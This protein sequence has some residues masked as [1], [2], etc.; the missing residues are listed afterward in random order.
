MNITGMVISEELEKITEFFDACISQ[1]DFS[2]DQVGIEDKR[3]QDLLHAIEFEPQAKE[4]YK[5]STKLHDSRVNRR[6]NK[7]QTEVLRPLYDFLNDERHRR[8]IQQLK[9]VLGA[10]RKAEK[11][12]LFRTY[13]PRVEEEE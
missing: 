4:R 1:Y 6:I 10:V 3:L 7:D 8:S 11:S 13:H 9:Q 5:L 12:H 2:W